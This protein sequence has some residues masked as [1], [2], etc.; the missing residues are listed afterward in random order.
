MPPDTTTVAYNSVWLQT[1]HFM[2][3]KNRVDR[4]PLASLPMKLGW[5]NTSARRGHLAPTVMMF[6]SRRSQIFS[7]SVDLS[8][9][10][11]FTSIVDGHTVTR[12][13]H[14][15]LRPSR[16]VQ[17]SLDRHVHGGHVERHEQESGPSSRGT[18]WRARSTAK[19]VDRN[20]SGQ[21][22]NTCEKGLPRTKRQGSQDHL[23][24]V[25]MCSAK[26]RNLLCRWLLKLGFTG[27]SSRIKVSVSFSSAD[28]G[29]SLISGMPQHQHRGEQVCELGTHPSCSRL[30]R[31]PR[32]TLSRLT[33]R[34]TWLQKQRDS[35]VADVPDG[36]ERFS[37]TG[38]RLFSPCEGSRCCLRA[39]AAEQHSCSSDATSVTRQK[40]TT[41]ANQGTEDGSD[42]AYTWERHLESG[43]SPN[44]SYPVSL[45]VADSVFRT[46]HVYPVLSCPLRP[47]YH[48]MCVIAGRPG[49][50][51]RLAHAAGRWHFTSA[52]TSG[53]SSL[54]SR[55]FTP[56]TSIQNMAIVCILT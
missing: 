8:S 32:G 56:E 24:V 1:S 20:V 52:S 42:G 29:S 4:S 10:S 41:S 21:K 51:Q 2:T 28:G 19:A 15:V 44:Q 50:L 39:M 36:H 43:C 6:S 3:F 26:S 22:V 37:M 23:F 49:C 18:Q 47:C 7:L 55:T 13:H 38:R 9:E 5:N 48:R 14:D 33:V 27:T 11:Q 45:K 30:P 17:D 25:F 12:V 40:M 16:N 35:D 31:W 53:R 54:C 34:S 46:R